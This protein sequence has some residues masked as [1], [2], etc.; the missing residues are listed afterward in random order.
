VVLKRLAQ[1]EGG[2]PQLKTLNFQRGMEQWQLVGLIT[3]R[4]VVRIHLPL[5]H[6]THLR[7]D[8]P[9]RRAFLLCC[10]HLRLRG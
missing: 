6:D 9:T 7:H 8:V 1:I 2:A 5:P 4:S 3:R 10:Q